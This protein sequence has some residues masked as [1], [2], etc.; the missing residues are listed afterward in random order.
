MEAPLLG[1]HN[2]QVLGEYLGY[3]PDRVHDLEAQ[4][5]LYRG[6]R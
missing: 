5:V 3:A 2:V 6:E 4:G 1:E